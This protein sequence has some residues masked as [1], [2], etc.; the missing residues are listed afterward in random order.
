MV[1]TA[2][3]AGPTRMRRSRGAARQQLAGWAF[4]G[5][6]AVTI[7][8]LFILPLAIVVFMS[9]SDWP[10]LGSP[11]LIGVGNYIEI[12]SDPGYI[13]AILFTLGY[14]ALATI[15]I[16]VLA[17]LLAAFLNTARR[18]AK[19]YRIAIFAPYVVGLSTASLMWVVNYND[20]VGIYAQAL[21]WLGIADGP[22]GFFDTPL[23]ATLAVT[24]MIVWKF[25]GFQVIIL[26]VALQSIPSSVNEASLMDGANAWQR[27]FYITLPFLRPTLALLLVLSVTGS[28]LAFDQFMVMTQGGPDN[29]T[30]TMVMKIYNT[31][32]TSFDLGKAAALSI[33]MLIA[34]VII[35]GLQLKFVKGSDK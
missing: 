1:T 33:V 29:S 8:V 14:T 12:F 32:F 26:L 28:L 18:G 7:L 20:Q 30:V 17:I 31:A 11:E 23:S 24:F 15:A 3:P 21:R 10:L 5:P 16:F 25:V 6:T 2:L 13:G 19:F 4:I 34:L 22:V 27:F 9:L 35:N